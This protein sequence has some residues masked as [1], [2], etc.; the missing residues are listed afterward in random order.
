MRIDGKISLACFTPARD[1]Q[2]ISPLPGFKVVRDLI[3]DWTPYE[4]RMQDFLPALSS[5]RVQAVKGEDLE[6]NGSP[7]SHTPSAKLPPLSKSLRSANKAEKVAESAATCI[8][9]FSCV[10]ACPTVDA[11]SPVGFAGPAISVMLAAHLDQKANSREY[12]SSIM[13]SHLEYC[14]RCYACNAVCPASINI[15][16]CIQELQEEAGASDPHAKR[17]NQMVTG[18]F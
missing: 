7:M 8:R 1:G 11:A 5:V 2:K 14:T 12:A 15:V 18:Y 10:G 17:L 6:R 16:E 9:C 3:V 4:K 13:R